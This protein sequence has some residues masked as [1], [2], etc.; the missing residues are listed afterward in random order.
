VRGARG[1]TSL[2][3]IL[4][5]SVVLSLAFLPIVASVHSMFRFSH[6]SQEATL[7]TFMVRAALENIRHRV[8]D[9][10]NRDSREL[11]KA[12]AEA[13]TPVVS[14]PG[15]KYVREFSN[16]EGTPG[17][18]AESNP[19]LFGQLRAARIKVEVLLADAAAAAPLDADGDM[20][21]EP[22]MCEVHVE[23]TWP[24]EKGGQRRQEAWTALTRL[25]AGLLLRSEEK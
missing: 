1:G 25:E 16:L 14:E 21:P 13:D 4:M 17:I 18:T 9:A 12:L 3:E 22:D 23:V 11:F 15:S 5:A 8:H 7:G 20:R 2:L 6:R 19:T 24:D 10:A